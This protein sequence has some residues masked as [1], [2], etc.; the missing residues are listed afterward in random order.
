MG[1]AWWP[2]A[3][4]T[5]R[6]PRSGSARRSR[7]TKISPRP[8]STWRPRCIHRDAEADALVEA[9]AALAVDPGLRGRAPAHRRAAAA[10]GPARRR[11]LGAGEAVRRRAR[12]GGRARGQ[13]A[14]ARAPRANARP[15][16]R[17]RA[18]RCAID[19][20]LPA[21][22]RAR[23]EILRRA[24]DLEAAS[25]E[26][27]I[28]IASQPRSIDDRLAHAT[29]AAARGLW[30]A[31]GARAGGAGR[32]GTAPA[33]RCSS[34]WR[35]SR[36]R[37][38]SGEAAAARRATP[39]WRCGR[40]TRRRGSCARRRSRASAATTRCVASSSGFS[41]RRRRRWPPNAPAP[42]E[43]CHARVSVLEIQ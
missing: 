30:A 35:S 9:R 28:V 43:C 32:G 39:R 7:S 42:N 6:A 36:S 14:R 40:P 38:A 23:A 22:H 10:A 19:P 29:I 17:R 8:T 4:A 11:A 16:S 37:A 34:R 15:P 12:A 5:G 18:G 1:W 20:Q 41:P 31:G 25:R 21:A 33:R 13:R 27:D 24:G 2:C 3:A 26:L